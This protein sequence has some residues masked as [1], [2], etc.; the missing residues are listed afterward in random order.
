MPFRIT[1]QMMFNNSL[2]NI[3]RQNE[4]MLKLQ[5]QLAS[6][7]R[8][9][10]PSDDPLGT[11][12]VLDLRSQKT[13]N[14]QFLRNGTGGTSRLN[15]T[16]SLL[17]RANSLAVRGKELALGQVGA[18]A[19]PQARATAAVE[20][21]QL[22]QDAINLGNEKTGSRFLFG[23]QDT[24]TAPVTSQGAYVGSPTRLRMNISSGNLLDIGVLASEFLTTDLNPAL[25]SSIPVADLHK[26]AGIGAGTFSITDRA[27]TTVNVTVSAGDTIG[28]VINAINSSGANVTAAISADGSGITI[29]D[30]NTTPTQNLTIADVSGTAAADL[31]IAGDRPVDSFTGDDL[32]PV[33]QAGTLLSSLLGGSGLTPGSIS[34]VNGATSATVTFAGATTVGDLINAINASGTNVTAGIDSTGTRLT[35]TSNSSST[36]AYAHDLGGGTT[37]EVLGIGG[38]RNLIL[39]LQ[40]LSAALKADDNA[41][42]L[43]AIDNLGT[44]TDTIQTVRGDVGART[45]QVE[46][47]QTTLE[48]S[49]FDIG[50]ESGQIEGA[51]A[52]EV[53]SNLALLQ[54]AFQATLRSTASIIQP[55]LLDF[56][57]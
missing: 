16:D 37:A 44:G 32:D 27:G 5:E 55:T 21:D 11:M 2:I 53:A 4:D 46:L 54:S 49:Q 28:N 13:A 3:F 9:N 26:G 15:Q 57:R 12:E 42:I 39:N 34:V 36:V 8:I 18:L 25:T 29:T 50:E 43:G 22:I 17:D 24:A 20:V 7:K 40:R 41:G 19:T 31:G 51:N 30:N 52:F 1:N 45:N 38:G 56:L 23:G 35:L 10:H 6:G 47:Q 14:E 33:V 48:G